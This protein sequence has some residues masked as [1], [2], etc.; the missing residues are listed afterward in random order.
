M[1]GQANIDNLHLRIGQSLIN[2][3]QCAETVPLLPDRF[4]PRQV[5]I[6][7]SPDGKTVFQSPKGGQM[8]ATYAGT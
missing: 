2:V 5:L 1:R 7:N 6:H 3:S 8:F 4:D